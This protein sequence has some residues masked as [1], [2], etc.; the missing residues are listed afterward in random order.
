MKTLIFCFI[1]FLGLS[2]YAVSPA[3]LNPYTFTG[4]ITDARHNGFDTNHLATIEAADSNGKLLARS[5]T[6]YRADSSRNYALVIPMATIAAEGY[7]TQ[8]KALVISAIDNAGDV[9]RGVVV[10]A[11]VGV[12]GGIREVDI[13]LSEDENGDGID[14]GLY[15]ELFIQWENSDYWRWGETFDPYKDYDEDGVSTIKEALSGTDPFNP[16]D[17]LRITRFFR[18]RDAAVKR[19]NDILELSFN[20]VGG[21]AYCVESASDLIKK[22]WKTCAVQIDSENDLVSIISLPVN[23]GSKSFTVYL[24]PESSTN[25]FYRIKTK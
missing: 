3:A 25:A 4:R 19:N 22:D 18:N 23:S 10:D 24:I 8:G 15:N 14:D 13:V 6:F 11:T 9:W 2:L 16:D 1:F 20:A 21:R 5:K 17:V 12:S 7:A